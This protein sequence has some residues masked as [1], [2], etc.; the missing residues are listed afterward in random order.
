LRFGPASLVV[1]KFPVRLVLTVRA[2]GGDGAS[3]EALEIIFRPRIILL[4]AAACL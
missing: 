4:A 3:R 1:Q 2:K